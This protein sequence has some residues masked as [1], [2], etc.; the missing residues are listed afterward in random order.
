MVFMHVS[1]FIRSW[2]VEQPSIMALK[3]SET[4]Y[5]L[6]MA[7]SLSVKGSDEEWRCINLCLFGVFSSLWSLLISLPLMNTVAE[8]V[9]SCCGFISFIEVMSVF[10]LCCQREGSR[11]V[12]PVFGVYICCFY[13]VE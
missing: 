5:G 1:H 10:F 12:V 6:H 3:S 11:V 7:F 8:L 4:S 9:S 13:V 2:L